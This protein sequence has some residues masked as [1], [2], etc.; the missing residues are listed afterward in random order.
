ML[1]AFGDG[2]EILEFMYCFCYLTIFQLTVY[3]KVWRVCWYTPK[4]RVQ[5]AG[6]KCQFSMLMG[7]IVTCAEH[8]FLAL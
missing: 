5:D 3:C 2:C 6:G 4:L 8:Q 7:V 1:V